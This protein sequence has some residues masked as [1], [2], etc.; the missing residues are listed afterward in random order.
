[1]KKRITYIILSILLLANEVFI[2]LFVHDRFIRPYVGDVL[3]VMVLY[4]FVRIFVPERIKALP[5]YLFGFR[6]GF[7]I[8]FGQIIHSRKADFPDCYS[9]THPAGISGIQNPFCELRPR[10]ECRRLWPWQH[11]LPWKRWSRQRVD[12]L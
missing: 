6:E 8:A 3:V 7:C 4:T 5:V 10:P 12:N 11:L 9:Q 2:A 1:M